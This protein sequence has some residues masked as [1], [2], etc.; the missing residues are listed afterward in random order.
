MTPADR[1]GLFGLAIF[2]VGWLALWWQVAIIL[3]GTCL[4]A[5]A[6]LSAYLRRER[7]AEEHHEG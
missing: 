6:V 5:G 4:V 2:F 1:L 3:L 7:A